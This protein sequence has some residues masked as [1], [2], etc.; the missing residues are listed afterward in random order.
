M[1]AHWFLRHVGLS[2]RKGGGP[3]ARMSLVR[4]KGRP[5]RKHECRLSEREG[6]SLL[7]AIGSPLGCRRQKTRDFREALPGSGRRGFGALDPQ[8]VLWNELPATDASQT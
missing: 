6:R 5:G 1:H 8:R 7:T 4:R 2:A 3:R